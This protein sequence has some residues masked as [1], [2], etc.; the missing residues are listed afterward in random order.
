M[1]KIYIVMDNSYDPDPAFAV[2]KKEDA[3]ALAECIYVTEEQAEK[4]VIEIPYIESVSVTEGDKV[5]TIGG[6]HVEEVPC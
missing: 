5:V 4:M 3:M 1:K 6:Q 2:D